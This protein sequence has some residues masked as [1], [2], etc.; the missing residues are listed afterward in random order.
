MVMDRPHVPFATCA[1][2]Y[3]RI[4]VFHFSATSRS[5]LRDSEPSRPKLLYRGYEGRTRFRQTTTIDNIGPHLPNSLFIVFE[6]SRAIIRC[7]GPRKQPVGPRCKTNW[8]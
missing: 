7:S 6:V 5:R 2:F 1:S 4:F 8:T 3:W